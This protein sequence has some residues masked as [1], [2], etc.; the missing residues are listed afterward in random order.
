MEE[1]KLPIGIEPNK[2][3]HQDIIVKVCKAHGVKSLELTTK[4]IALMSDCISEY[5]AQQPQQGAAWVKASERLPLDKAFWNIE[6]GFKKDCSFPVRIDGSEYGM[7]ELYDNRK[8]GAPDPI[9][10][11]VV[12]G[13]F[14]KEYYQ[15]EFHR[16]E[17]LDE[18]TS[19]EG[20]K[21]REIAFLK[22]I[23]DQDGVNKLTLI[24]NNW[25]CDSDKE[26][27]QP[28]SEEKLWNE[29]NNQQKK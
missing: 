18:S 3:S 2:E 15:N 5:I 9:Y 22:W 13:D 29:W 4:H 19:K 27:N 24:D 20:N 17:W 7:A 8:D 25:Y 1:K 12:K 6:D 16:F 14:G 11:L 21:E 28:L 23:A 26:G 10:Y